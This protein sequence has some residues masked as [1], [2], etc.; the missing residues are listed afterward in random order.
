LNP[1]V[2]AGPAPSGAIRDRIRHAIHGRDRRF[3]AAD[4][5]HD[6]HFAV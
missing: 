5:S 2:G 3:P 1:S 4:A 6:R